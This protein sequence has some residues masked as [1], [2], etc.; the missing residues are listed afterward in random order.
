V[1]K[2]QHQ[3][4]FAGENPETPKNAANADGFGLLGFLRMLFGGI[5]ASSVTY[6]D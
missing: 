5:L 6:D 4:S 3:N 2:L 1:L